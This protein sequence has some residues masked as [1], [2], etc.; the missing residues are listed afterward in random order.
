MTTDVDKS[1]RTW[2]WDTGLP[3][4]G[5]T[6]GKRLTRD[7]CKG[8]AHVQTTYVVMSINPNL[9]HMSY[10]MGIRS[11]PGRYPTG[12]CQ[13]GHLSK[14]TK[15]MMSILQYHVASQPRRG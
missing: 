13:L 14:T 11:S 10:D 1:I 15:G 6:T 4:R 12:K 8:E 5:N 3:R 9:G 2:M 7:I